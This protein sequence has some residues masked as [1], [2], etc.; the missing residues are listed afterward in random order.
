MSGQRV[1]SRRPGR[2]VVISAVGSAS[3]AWPAG[4]TAA[5]D[6]RLVAHMVAHWEREIAVVLPDRPDLIVL[7]EMCDRYDGTPAEALQRLRPLMHERMSAALRALA[8]RH[9]CHIAHASAAP[10]R[11]GRWQNTVSLIG[12]DGGEIARYAKNRLVLTELGRGLVPGSGPVVAECDFGRVGFAIC[13]DL[14]FTELIDAYRALAP[15]LILF[16]SRYHGGLMQPFW[17]YQT[18]A[19]FVG[20]TGQAPI[21]S[22]IWSPVGQRLAASTNYFPH[23]TAAVNLDCAVVHL[24]FNWEKLRALKERHGRDVL[25]GDPGELGAILVSS[26]SETHSARDMLRDFGIEPLDSYLARS[27]AASEA[28]RPASTPLPPPSA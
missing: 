12:R 14:N 19:H 8:H 17:A 13:F 5:D 9:R 23:V 20:C 4:A 3:P 2:H 25:I 21:S 16:P 1:Q 28:A 24:D 6:E 7:P 18:R 22:D 27:R 10:A 15:D 26:R 11:D